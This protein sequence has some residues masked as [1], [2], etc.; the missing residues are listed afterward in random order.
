MNPTVTII[1]TSHMKPT[2]AD[3]IASVIS[4]TR[5]DFECVVMDSGQWRN[6]DD[7]L[8]QKMHFIY[9]TSQAPHLRWEFTDEEP[10]LHD[11][12]CPVGWATNEA[13]SRGLVRGKYVCTFYD[14]DLYDPR[15]VETMAGYLDEHPDELAVWCSQAR[16][17]LRDGRTEETG[18]IMADRIL[19]PGTIDCRVD[20]GQVMFRREVIEQM[21]D[22]WMT[23]E[24]GECWHSDGVF[25][26][27]LV[28][29]CGGE[30]RPV[31]LMDPLMTH[32]NT[33]YSTYSRS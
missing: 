21:G 23:E 17:A 15:F 2:L 8:S 33:P 19:T 16:A 31:G 24:R 10:G 30:I 32:R 9:A 29:L 14:D 5:M 25:L 4:Q 22:R 18:R 1:L 27:K 11:R 26:E 12:V 7:E 20:G 3:A 6:K 13:T 28:L